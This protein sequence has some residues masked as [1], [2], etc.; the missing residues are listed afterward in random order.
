MAANR[1]PAI[2]APECSLAI[3]RQGVLLG[4]D[5][6][7]LCH[8]PIKAT[9]RCAL[10]VAAT[11]VAQITLRRLTPNLPRAH[12]LRDLGLSSTKSCNASQSDSDYDWRALKSVAQES[13]RGRDRPA[14]RL[15]AW[16]VHLMLFRAK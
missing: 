8:G 13:D 7:I 9:G 1:A 6:F 14:H 15:A 16:V 4:N 11:N 10:V 5:F 3:S 12:C 2:S